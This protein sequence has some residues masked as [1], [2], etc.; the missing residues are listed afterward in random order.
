[1]PKIKSLTKIFITLAA[2][3]LLSTPSDAK[4]V[5]IVMDDIGYHQADLKA[6]QLPANI[7]FAILPH[8]PFADEFARRANKQN[9]E[10]ILHMPMEAVSGKALGPGALTNDMNKEQ[11]QSTLNKALD[12]YPQVTGLNNHMGSYLTQ[13]VVPMSWTMEVLRERNLFFL[14][15][16]TT[17]DSKAQY[18]ANLFGVNNIARHVFIDNIPTD[19]QM[20]FRLN[21]LIRIAK[22]RGSAVAIAHPY[23]E[24]L[25]FLNDALPKL[26][27]EGIEVVKISELVDS[28][29]I[30]LAQK[31]TSS[32]TNSVK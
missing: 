26:K 5:A 23:P 31:Q 8:T 28:K 9:K 21:Q 20:Q 32:N 15:S 16:K 6:L 18:M 14:D 25:A 27:N 4:Q 10:L 3:V 12:S 19:K 22:K 24:T 1:M 11:I 2:S 29:Y 13:K 17:R 30:Q 7:S